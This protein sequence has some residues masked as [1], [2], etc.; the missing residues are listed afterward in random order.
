MAYFIHL[1]H[2]SSRDAEPPANAVHGFFRERFILSDII[3]TC[4]C[5]KATSRIP[6]KPTSA[7]ST[8]PRTSP[9]ARP[10]PRARRRSNPDELD[11]SRETRSTSPAKTLGIETIQQEHPVIAPPPPRT[12]SARVLRSARRLPRGSDPP[13][14][15]VAAAAEGVDGTWRRETQC[16]P[17]YRQCTFTDLDL[18]MGS[19]SVTSGRTGR[20]GRRRAAA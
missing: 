13:V 14:E 19:P 1:A 15:E 11:Q 18:A 3:C 20:T 4:R 10:L 6:C 17:L 7:T 8:L 12:H 2:T 5:R 9:P 16:L